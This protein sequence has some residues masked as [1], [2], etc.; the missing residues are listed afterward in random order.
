VNK[1]FKISAIIFGASV[2][3][4]ILFLWSVVD[5][6]IDWLNDPI[7]RANYLVVVSLV[8]GLNAISGFDLLVTLLS[9]FST[10]ITGIIKVARG[11]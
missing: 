3:I 7:Y 11:Q 6:P 2:T 10:M 5:V 9:L 4:L 8:K 1:W